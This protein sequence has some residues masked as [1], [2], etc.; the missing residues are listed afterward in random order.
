MVSEKLAQYR[1]RLIQYLRNLESKRSPRQ[2]DGSDD[3]LPLEDSELIKKWLWIFCV[4]GFPAAYLV[5]PVILCF[6]RTFLWSP[7][8]DFLWFVDYT[9]MLIVLATFVLAIYLTVGRRSE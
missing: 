3:V 7:L 5:A 9:L 6:V 4:F 8:A 1:V 2:E